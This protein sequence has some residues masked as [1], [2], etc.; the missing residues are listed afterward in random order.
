VLEDAL[1]LEIVHRLV[2]HGNL[3]LGVVQLD[4]PNPLA[5]ELVK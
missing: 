1:A 2:R 4:Q 5:G 3:R